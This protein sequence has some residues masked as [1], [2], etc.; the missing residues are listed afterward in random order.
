[1]SGLVWA[2]ATLVHPSSVELRHY[3]VKALHVEVVRAADD[4]ADTL[5]LLVPELAILCGV[6][7]TLGLR[8]VHRLDDPVTFVFLEPV[9]DGEFTA[10]DVFCSEHQWIKFNESYLLSFGNR[11]FF[12]F[13]GLVFL[14]SLFVGVDFLPSLVVGTN[15]V[16]NRDGFVS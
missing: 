9:L 13:S 11:N 3:A 2:L 10:C 4:V 6:L 5:P 15:F 7:V 14:P 1:M 16:R 12:P 8:N